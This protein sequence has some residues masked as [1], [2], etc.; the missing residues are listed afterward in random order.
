MISKAKI[1][2]IRALQVKKYRKDEQCFV[3]EGTKSVVELLQS[4]FEVVWVGATVEFIQHFE[5]LLTQKKREVVEATEQELEAAGSFQSNTSALAIARMKPN[6][7]FPIRDNEWALV[8]D[9][10]R[11]PGNLGTIIRT[12]DWYG[13]N[14]II[15]SEATADFYNPKVISATMGSFCRVNVFYT[16]LLPYLQAAR[17]PVYGTFLDG[18]D[19][20]QLQWSGGGL[21]VIGNEAN[22]IS[23]AIE[24]LL[25]QKITIP[26][27]GRAES[28]NAAL[29]TGIVL[30]VIR[31]KK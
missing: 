12:A 6:N 7:A 15:A 24:K 8:L 14:H 1:K 10:I 17:K 25:T 3:V 23:P 27:Y 21:L 4:D 28:L 5:P 19:V 31:S 9:D 20:H 16:N 2:H 13:V 22:G 29:A 30:D 26:R 18:T 11:D